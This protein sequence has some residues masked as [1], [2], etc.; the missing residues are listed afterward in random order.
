MHPV[1]LLSKVQ[2]VLTTNVTPSKTNKFQS[3]TAAISGPAYT[4]APEF[5]PMISDVLL[6]SHLAGVVSFHSMVC[7]TYCAYPTRH[8]YLCFSQLALTFSCTLPPC[9]AAPASISSL[10]REAV[11]L[12]MLWLDLE[13]KTGKFRRLPDDARSM[14]RRMKSFCTPC[15]RL[16][17][18]WPCNISVLRSILHA[19]GLLSCPVRL[20]AHLQST[21]LSLRVDTK[22]AGLNHP[23]STC[24]HPRQSHKLARTAH[25]MPQQ[26][27]SVSVSILEPVIRPGWFCHCTSNQPRLQM[28]A[29][30]ATCA[31][32]QA[33]TSRAAGT[34]GAAGT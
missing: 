26:L 18:G 2:Q 8:I 34:L 21:A 7:R 31:V 20:I 30:L 6:L 12:H 32:S 5:L 25:N 24:A 16:V 27:I 9:H 19:F 4:T 29:V 28:T 17:C 3:V 14:S 23:R 33:Q 22:E 13:A 11:K 1:R 10:D 15:C